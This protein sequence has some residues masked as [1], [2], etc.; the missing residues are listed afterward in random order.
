MDLEV[1]TPLAS[2]E[3]TDSSKTP[4]YWEGAIRAAGHKGA[5]AIDGV[6]YLEMTG[7]E[8]PVVMGRK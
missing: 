8:R 5:P 3:L 2:Q 4:T 7:Y 6:G 1:T